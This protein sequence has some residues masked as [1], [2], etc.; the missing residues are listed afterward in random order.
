MNL[1][2][3]TLQIIY[4]SCHSLKEKRSIIQ[5]FFSKI[6]K[7]FNVSIAEVEGQDLWQKSVVGVVTINS[8]TNELQRTLDYV[9]NYVNE[10]PDL[11]VVD[12]QVEIL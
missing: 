5:S 1:G 4:P 12:Y 10:I 3:L 6:R 2:V 8:S 11:L 7:T 9:V